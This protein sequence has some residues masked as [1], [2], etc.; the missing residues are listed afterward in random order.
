ML[1]K[2]VMGPDEYHG[3]T[4]NN[5]YTNVVAGLAIYL[6]EYA[7]CVGGCPQVPPSWTQVVS[8]ALF[9]IT[10]SQVAASIALE[11]SKE[12]DFH[13]QYRGYT[14]GTA[15][16]QADTV[17]VR[18]NMLITLCSGWISPHVSDGAVYQEQRLDNIRGSH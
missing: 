10:M 4:D 2:G 14:P 16:K 18:L 1:H 13:P 8:S 9:L 11:Y 5:V 3:S 6:A 17:L 12:L 7:Q 15:I